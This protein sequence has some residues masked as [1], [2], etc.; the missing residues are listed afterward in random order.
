M[1]YLRNFCAVAALTLS[2]TLSAYAGHIPCPGITEE[3][4]SEEV[5]AAGETPNNIMDVLLIML[6]LI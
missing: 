3:P 1:K 6:S 4:P 5:T 2:F